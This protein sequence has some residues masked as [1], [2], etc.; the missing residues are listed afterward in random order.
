MAQLITPPIC[1][2]ASINFGSTTVAST[3]TN[4]VSP[5]NGSSFTFN[6]TFTV[7]IQETS[8]YD[9]NPILQYNAN[10]L[11]ADMWFGLPNGNSYK[12][13]SIT[14]VNTQGTSCVLVLKDVDLYNLVVDNTGN[15][16]NFPPEGFIGLFFTI[17]SDGLP[18][19]TPTEQIRSQIGDI[20]NWLNDLHDRFRLRNYITDYFTININDTSYS[21]I[22]EG[23]FVKI[24]SSGSFVK[25]TGTTENDLLSIAGIVSSADTP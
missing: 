2:P 8:S 12:I 3:Y 15:G 17:G 21:G 6:C 22:V 20:T 11:T 9:T 4:A 25:V 24:N 18:V 23:N 10:N 13:Q 14:S 7:L 1:I 19:I 5:W 16:N